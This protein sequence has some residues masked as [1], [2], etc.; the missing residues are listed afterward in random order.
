MRLPVARA[1]E[2]I[3][4][5]GDLETRRRSALDAVRLRNDAFFA[6]EAIDRECFS[7]LQAIVGAE[8][9]AEALERAAYERAFDREL[10][11][12]DLLG[13]AIANPFTALRDAELGPETRMRVARAMREAMRTLMPDV[14]RARAASFAV[15]EHFDTLVF[16]GLLPPTE[17]YGEAFRERVAARFQADRT[18]EKSL[19]RFLAALAEAA[20]DE[21]AALERAYAALAMREDDDRGSA[22]VSRA[23]ARVGRLGLD[24]ARTVE[25]ASLA[26]AHAEERAALVLERAI[27]DSGW[28]QVRSRYDEVS[29]FSQLIEACDDR[30]VAGIVAIL[31]PAERAAVIGGD[32][33]DRTLDGIPDEDA[34]TVQ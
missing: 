18:L 6:C 16:D 3:V 8:A 11:S 33:L 10:P 5:K 19:S 32:S 13:C 30:L 23:L 15:A 28:R 34:A 31:T 12:I 7:S 22:A 24:E 1:K 20:G 9:E 26:K 14:R 25:I 29:R 4:V 27:V 17:A 2:T 21:R